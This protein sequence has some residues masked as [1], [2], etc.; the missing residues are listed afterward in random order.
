M[1]LEYI[2]KIRNSP[3]WYH[4]ALFLLWEYDYVASL[5]ERREEAKRFIMGGESGEWQSVYD[6]PV[7]Q[8]YIDSPLYKRMEELLS[9]VNKKYTVIQLGAA[10]GREIKYFR[11][12]YPQH[13]YIATDIVPHG[14]VVKLDVR[15]IKKFVRGLQNVI[16]FTNGV[17]EYVQPEYI[18]KF[19][20]DTAGYKVL[21]YEPVIMKGGKMYFGYRENFAWSHNY[22]AASAEFRDIIY[23]KM[24]QTTDNAGCVFM[25][26]V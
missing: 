17:L 13:E 8:Q 23:F 6:K 10:R 19:F 3:K 18:S 5:P 11:D 12:K 1:L 2:K 26:V 4:R 22:W 7:E 14:D 21:I 24:N 16:I 9:F 20:R 15:D 25:E